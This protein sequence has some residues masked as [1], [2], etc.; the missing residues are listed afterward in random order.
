MTREDTNALKE[1]RK[2]MFLAAYCGG[3]AHLA[4]AFS[5]AEIF[6]ALYQ[7]DIL[8]IDVSAPGDENRDRLILSKGHASLALYASLVMKGFIREEELYTFIQ[9]GSRLSGEPCLNGIP[10]VEAAT[11][12]LGH[13]LSLGLGMAL[14]GKLDGRKSRVY[15]VLGDGECQEG[16]I[17]EAVMAAHRYEL[18]N[19]TAILDC[20]GIQKMGFIRETMKISSWRGKWESFGWRVDEI[21]DGHN[22]DEVCRVL[23]Q[24][25]EADRPRL[26][27]AHTVK[28]KGVSIMENEPNWHFK[29]PNRREL[30]VFMEELGITQ[31]ELERC[32]KHI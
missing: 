11:G 13:G 12:S 30:K 18:G 10:G 29:M 22:L 2:K 32:K 7:K 25:T 24:E 14:A 27:L 23:R 16:S 8:H 19:L 3:S 15:V 4:S 6:Y 9:P 17:W 21:E 26:V 31:E 20:N 5:A 1:M 28:G